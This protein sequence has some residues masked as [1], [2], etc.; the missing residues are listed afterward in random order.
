MNTHPTRRR[1]SSLELRRC[2]LCGKPR[3]V[4]DCLV[5]ACAAAISRVADLTVV[6]T[7]PTTA[8]NAKMPAIS[9]F[10]AIRISPKNQ[11]GIMKLERPAALARR[12][13][14]VAIASFLTQT[15]V[16]DVFVQWTFENAQFSDGG[17]LTGFDFDA[18]IGAV[19]DWSVA[20]P[21]R[22]AIPRNTKSSSKPALR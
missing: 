21:G 18:T 7:A 9:V 19:T 22:L 17:A 2:S 16:A 4:L 8:T 12:V 11:C 10:P 20:L 5:C 15:A 3:F 13:L 6:A 14:A 1:S